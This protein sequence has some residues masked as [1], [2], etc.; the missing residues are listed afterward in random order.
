MTE[1]A[2]AIAVD[3]TGDGSWL[4]A[5]TAT[6]GR[7]WLH[8]GLVDRRTWGPVYEGVMSVAGVASSREIAERAAN[9]WWAAS[10]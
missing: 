8:F 6:R 5:V 3:Q 7:L 1:K 4:W 10:R 2:Y 9:S